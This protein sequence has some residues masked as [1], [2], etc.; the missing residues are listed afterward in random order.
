[1]DTSMTDSLAVPFYYKVVEIGEKNKE[2]NKK[3]LLKAYGYLGG[4][5]ANITKNYLAS[6]G[7]FERYFSIEE[8]AEIAQYIEMLRKW[9]AEKK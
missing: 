2:V 9:I 7:W 3:M 1:M 5:E 4:Y 8:N 6:L